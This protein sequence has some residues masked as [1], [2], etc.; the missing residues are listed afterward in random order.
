MKN[1]SNSHQLLTTDQTTEVFTVYQENQENNAVGEE[2]VKRVKE[3]TDRFK[4]KECQVVKQELW[5]GIMLMSV[6]SN[7]TRIKKN[8]ITFQKKILPI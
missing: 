5:T 6:K 2:T 8:S 3:T 4:D 7:T 1:W